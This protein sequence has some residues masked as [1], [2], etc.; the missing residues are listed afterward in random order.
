MKSS[1]IAATL[2]LLGAGPEHVEGLRACRKTADCAIATFTARSD[3]G[4]PAQVTE[5]GENAYEVILCEGDKS[6]QAFVK[7]NQPVFTTGTKCSIE[8]VPPG[9]TEI[10]TGASET[11]TIKTTAATGGNSTE[12]EYSITARRLSVGADQSECEVTRER[13]AIEDCGY[14]PYLEQKRLDAA[15]NNLPPPPAPEETGFL[16]QARR[17]VQA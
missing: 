13:S 12:T 8:G 5:S 9:F 11:F 15:R 4:R 17:H 10:A 7:Q 14:A 6:F 3:S 16:Q 2:A 1:W